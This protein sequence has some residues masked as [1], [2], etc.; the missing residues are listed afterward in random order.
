MLAS[1]QVVKASKDENSRLFRGLRGGGSNFGIIT[2]FE[3]ELFPYNGMWGGRTTIHKS[4]AEDALQAYVNFLPKL[5]CDPKGHTIIIFDYLNQDVVVRQYLAYT[6]P[7]ADNPIFEDLRKVPTV[8]S[9]LGFTDYSDLAA[10]IATLQGDVGLRPAVSTITVRLDYDLLKFAYETYVEEAAIVDGHGGGCLEFHALPRSP[11]PHDN[12]YGLEN[13]SRPL[14]SIMLAFATV[15]KR[16]DFMLFA[17]QDRILGRIRDA[18]EQRGLFHPFL[19]ANYAG[20]FQDVT[21]SYGEANRRILREIAMEYDPEGVFQRL[22]PG[23]FKL[24]F[25][26][27]KMNC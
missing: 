5:E 27:T 18:A 12:M 24:G 8:D 3:L 19:F 10:D 26:T 16:Y 20:P 21:G 17:L 22:Q 15:D 14:V 9:A 11:K 6:Q 1:G 4:H 2:A 25:G 23:G 13:E 7:V